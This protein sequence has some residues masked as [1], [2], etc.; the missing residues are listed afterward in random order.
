MFSH[1]NTQDL[2]FMPVAFLPPP[3]P[4]TPR[5]RLIWK[6][7]KF[8][9]ERYQICSVLSTPDPFW[10]PLAAKTSK[11]PAA[12]EKSKRENLIMCYPWTVKVV[13]GEW[14]FNGYITDYVKREVT[15]QV[16][17]YI[18][19]YLRKGKKINVGICRTAVPMHHSVCTPLLMQ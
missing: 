9:Q 16:S 6:P 19:S 12:M 3:H 8:S 13:N 11:S 14:C 1:G 2:F 18:G 7:S 5:D 15:S 4:L 10:F 17:F